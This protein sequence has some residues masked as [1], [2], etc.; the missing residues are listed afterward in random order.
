MWLWR[1]LTNGDFVFIFAL[2]ALVS[3]TNR[4][5]YTNMKHTKMGALKIERK[6]KKNVFFSFSFT[7][8]KQ[9][10]I[11]W[12][13]FCFEWRGVHHHHQQQYQIMHA[14]YAM[15][16]APYFMLWS[17]S[18]LLAHT[19]LKA[20][21]TFKHFFFFRFSNLIDLVLMKVLLYIH[22]KYV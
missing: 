18:M 17:Q 16:H 14:N 9:R 7:E 21:Y 10:Q 3:I 6:T 1:R 13:N 19:L 20:R 8:A 5:K 2:Y 22:T 12:F 11:R 4:L 15:N